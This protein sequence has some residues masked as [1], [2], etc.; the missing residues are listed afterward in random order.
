MKSENP[1]PC[2]QGRDK[3][4]EVYAHS[5]RRT[6]RDK[7]GVWMHATA[8]KLQLMLFHAARGMTAESVN[9][10]IAGTVT[11]QKCR[12]TLTLVAKTQ[13]TY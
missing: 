13:Q 11:M 6:Q 3:V 4:T 12:R 2:F 9:R 10:S 5:V 7:S 8:T 1:I